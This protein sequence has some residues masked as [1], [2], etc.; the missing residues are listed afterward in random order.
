MPMP[1]ALPL[2]GRSVSGSMSGLGM[3][4]PPD[5]AHLPEGAAYGLAAMHAQAI[6]SLGAAAGYEQPQQR[7]FT[8]P[9]GYAEPEGWPA[10]L[11]GAELGGGSLY[12]Q[13]M[14]MRMGLWP[15]QGAPFHGAGR[16]VM[17]VNPMM[18]AGQMHGAANPLLHEAGRAARPFAPGR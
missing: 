13:Q 14:A 17:P 1:A 11:R 5:A 6:G 8:A 4:M 3:A 15:N 7:Y 16:M 2:P 18:P 9:P 12:D 10:S